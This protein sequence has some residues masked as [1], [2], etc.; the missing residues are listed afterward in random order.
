MYDTRAFSTLP[1]RQLVTIDTKTKKKHRVPLSQASEASFSGDGSTVFFVRPSYHGNVTK[2]YKGGTARQLWKYTY[3]QPEA[4]KL[5]TDFAGGSHHPMWYNNRVYFITDRDGTMNIWSINENG[6]DLK[7]HTKHEGFDVR[8]AKQ[9]NGNFVYQVGADIWH[10]NLASDT[11]KKINI[12]LLSDLD[13]LR[14]KW[15]EN[16]AR[17]ITSV[18][19]DKKGE[20]I[21]VTSR[22]RAFVFPVK[23]GRA[24]EFTHQKNVRYRD[25]IFSANGK[26][27]Y[28]LSDESGEFE[29][30]KMGANGEG[31]PSA[32]TKNGNSCIFLFKIGK[33]L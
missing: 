30:I 20:R 28:T 25:A 7:Q 24:V 27:I 32:I 17:Y 33:I 21:V 3:G 13:Q 10:Y 19:P 22:G 12:R 15:E 4:V 18:F 1:D 29:F 2:R 6:E 8:Y 31:E 26:E 11:S 9:H 14:E 16:P 5:T 23:S